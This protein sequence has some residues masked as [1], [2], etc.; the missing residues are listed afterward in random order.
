MTDLQASQTER[1]IE[2][3]LNCGHE[4]ATGLRLDLDDAPNAT[5]RV[6][7]MILLGRLTDFM[8]TFGVGY[9]MCDPDE[10]ERAR[11]T[12]RRFTSPCVYIEDYF[13][14]GDIAAA[15]VCGIELETTNER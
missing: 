3:V 7:H 11:Y 8:W 13:H 10:H 9:V 1:I 14:H 2:A 4:L 5:E 15:W 6:R 12:A